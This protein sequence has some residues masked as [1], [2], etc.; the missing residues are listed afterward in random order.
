MDKKALKAFAAAIDEEVNAENFDEAT[1]SKI[2]E[3]LGEVMKKFD[4]HKFWV[5]TM[6]ETAKHKDISNMYGVDM[7]FVLELDSDN[8]SEE[9]ISRITA[10]LAAM[11]KKED[12]KYAVYMERQKAK[13]ASL[14]FLPMNSIELIFNYGKSPAPVG[15]KFGGKPDVCTQFEWPH[16]FFD[17]DNDP[18]YEPEPLTFACQINLEEAAAY[19]KDGLLPKSGMLYFFISPYEDTCWEDEGNMFRVVYHNGDLS[20]LKPCEFPKNYLEEFIFPDTL[21]TFNSVESLAEEEYDEECDE[22]TGDE[23]RHKLLGYADYIQNDILVGYFDEPLEWTL[24]F[25][26]DYI[27]RSNIYLMYGDG[28]KVYYY[29]KKSDLAKCD[30]SKI[31]VEIQCY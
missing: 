27:D 10:I 7:S 28:G 11:K 15:S 9:D 5:D 17:P 8:L 3:E 16:T 20:E 23:T 12:E 29:I 2:K 30:F 22:D 4:V 14:N 21:I 13:R 6:K 31:Y 1:K 26:L 18:E 25:Q 19:D 24:L